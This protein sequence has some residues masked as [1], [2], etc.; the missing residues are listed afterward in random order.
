M[1]GPTGFVRPR[2]QPPVGVHFTATA[3]GADVETRERYY[4]CDGV[5]NL[6]RRIV[7]PA[8]GIRALWFRHTI[9]HPLVKWEMSKLDVIERVSAGPDRQI[10]LTDRDRATV[11]SPK[12]CKPHQLIVAPR[13]A[14]WAR[15][16]RSA[17]T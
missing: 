7:G 13:W 6:A 9:M 15:L 16:E 5:F 8:C 14:M 10:S 3:D 17:A 12:T 2:A 1:L 11:S 4:D